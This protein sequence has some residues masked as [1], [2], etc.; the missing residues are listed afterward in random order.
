MR[1]QIFQDCLKKLPGNPYLLGDCEDINRME[2]RSPFPNAWPNNDTQ[3]QGLRE[4]LL[5][6]P[7]SSFFSADIEQS[8]AKF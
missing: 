4:Y 3:Q 2:E 1:H 6:I 7:W 8:S 5:I